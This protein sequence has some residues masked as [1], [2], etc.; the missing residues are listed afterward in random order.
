[1]STEGLSNLL[2]E[3]RTF[4]PSAEFV[5]QANAGPELFEQAQAGSGEAAIEIVA[6]TSSL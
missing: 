5:A 1:M 3:E 2:H 4:E 6:N